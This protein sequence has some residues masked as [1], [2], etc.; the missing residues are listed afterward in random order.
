MKGHRHIRRKLVGALAALVVFCTTYALILPAVTL[1]T[2]AHCGKEEHTH[3]SDC[4]RSDEYLC[5]QEESAVSEGHVHDETCYQDVQ[6]VICGLEENE[7]HTHDETCYQTEQVLICDK[8]ESEGAE[9]HTHTADCKKS[10]EP[11]CGKEEHTHSRQ[12]ESDPDAVETEEDWKKSLPRDLKEDVRERILQVAES[13]LGYRESEKNFR[14]NE[15]KTED[16]FTRYGEWAGDRYGDWNNAFTGWVLKY[17]EVDIAFEND[18]GKWINDLQDELT[19]EPETGMA[20]FFRDDNAVLRSG[21]V[22]GIKDTEILVIE[23]DKDKEVRETKVPRDQFVAYLDTARKVEIV[24]P[25]EPG[26]EGNDTE[27]SAMEKSVRIDGQK[28]VEIGDEV[29]LTAQTAGFENEDSLTY[30]WQ[31]KSGDGDWTDL[32]DGTD[33]THLVIVDEENIDWIYRVGVQEQPEA[34]GGIPVNAYPRLVVPGVRFDE[35]AD[36]NGGESGT[37]YSDEFDF[38]QDSLQVLADSRASSVIQITKGW[39]QSHSAYTSVDINIYRRNSDAGADES[40]VGELVD[41]VTLSADNNWTTTWNLPDGETDPNQFIVREAPISGWT[42]L[43]TRFDPNH[44]LIAASQLNKNDSYLIMDASMEHFLTLEDGRLVTKSITVSNSTERYDPANYP[45]SAFWTSDSS[46]RLSNG[47]FYL[48]TSS[49]GLNCYENS[50]YGTKFSYEAT[51]NN[52]NG[53][54]VSRGLYKDSR[55]VSFS[56]GTFSTSKTTNNGDR[57]WLFK[58][59]SSGSGSDAQ[60]VLI[61]NTPNYSVNPDA[62]TGNDSLAYGFP[63]AKQIDYLGDGVENKDTDAAENLENKYRLYLSAGPIAGDAAETPVNIL[64]VVDTS[65]SMKNNNRMSNANKAIENSWSA[66]RSLNEAKNQMSVVEFGSQSSVSTDWTSAAWGDAD[67]LKYYDNW[68]GGTNYQAGLKEAE[69]QIEKIRKKNN[70]PIFMVFLSDGAATYGG[71][72]EPPTYYSNFPNCDYGNGQ[73]SYRA[74][75]VQYTLQEIINFRQKYPDVNIS[76]IGLDHS[77]RNGYFPLL[78]TGNQIYNGTT[79]TLVD[80]MTAVIAGPSITKGKIV[81]KLSD[82]VQ[83]SEVPNVKLVAKDKQSNHEY[84]LWSDGQIQDFILTKLGGGTENQ[85]AVFGSITNPVTWNV[86]D[87]T[88]QVEFN[89][90][91]NMNTRYEY[92]LSFD[93]DVT[94]PAYEKFVETGY[95][96]TGDEETDVADNTTSSAKNGFYSNVSGPDTSAFQF[97]FNNKEYKREYFKPVVQVHQRID[98]NKVDA[99]NQKTGLSGAVFTLYKEGGSTIAGSDYSGTVIRDDLTTGAN[100]QLTLPTLE[101]GTYYLQE[102]KAPSGY[103][104][105]GTVWK[106]TLTN[107]LDIEGE[108]LSFKGTSGT[109][110]NGTIEKDPL[111]QSFVLQITNTAGKPLPNTGGSGTKLLTSAGGVMIAGSLLMYGY[112]KRLRGKERRL[113]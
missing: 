99:A 20:G 57:V 21:I 110:S 56:N 13:Q 33:K 44:L 34:V 18:L 67:Y 88:I 97:S 23:G 14:V 24:D 93:V 68:N 79:G 5:G 46:G 36:I 52:N 82:Y 55:K 10:D 72:C 78:A 43:Y 28:Q 22:K 39:T 1:S 45:E 92:V 51:K 106:L 103:V 38:N 63:I 40:E 8:E 64:Y 37:I 3:T 69:T 7:F 111:T 12:C 9:G 109:S 31:Y 42:G 80:Q 29:T 76:V 50:N 104:S 19:Q 53:E 90:D 6:T 4:Y 108:G 58:V 100:G 30:Q 49:S 17:G 85:K 27:E 62:G 74:E 16:G 107:K 96:D 41:K 89:P 61:T 2:E 101:Q 32:P 105:T 81:D 102:T 66:I 73:D 86:Q 48:N 70:Y 112:R 15:D 91:W 84:T 71:A 95:P 25:S 83:F 77:D 98:L 65:G 113:K 35:T 75:L 59:H 87:K 94:D 11:I 60:K 54:D 47:G 26:S